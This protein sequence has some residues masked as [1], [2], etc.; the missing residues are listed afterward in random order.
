MRLLYGQARYPQEIIM[1]ALFSRPRRHDLHAAFA[2]RLYHNLIFFWLV[3]FFYPDNTTLNIESFPP[4]LQ[5]GPSHVI[6]SLPCLYLSEPFF[7]KTKERTDLD[8][9]TG[10]Y[11][12][13]LFPFYPFRTDVLR[14]VPVPSTTCSAVS[15]LLRSPV[16]PVPAHRTRSKCLIVASKRHWT[17]Y[18]AQA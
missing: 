4:F 9:R 17:V 16:C 18:P 10:T 7:R 1:M 3:F 5:H 14:L 13:V 12:F 2:R 6:W 8:G 11:Y 15:L